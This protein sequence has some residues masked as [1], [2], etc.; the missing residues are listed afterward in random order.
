VGGQLEIELGHRLSRLD[1]DVRLTVDR[2]T[3]ALVGPSGSGKSTILR[4]I[5]GLLGPDRGRIVHD[6]R[7][8]LDTSRGVNLS[9]DAR[10]IGLVYQD[11]ALFPFM[12]VEQN[13]AY[14]VRADRSARARRARSILDRF[15]IGGLAASRPGDLSGGE[16]QRVALARAVASE[17][18]ILL[19]D[20][21]LSALDAVTKAEVA[22]EIDTRLRELRLPTILVSHDFADVVALAGRVAVLQEGRIVQVGPSSELVE[23]PASG[24]VASLAGVNYFAGTARPRDGLTEVSGEGWP[25]PL[26][27]TD[28]ALGPVGVVVYPW[29]ISLGGRAPAGSAL[30][31]IVG[32]VRRIVPIGNRSRVS[33]DGSPPVVAEVTEDSVRHLGLA[34]GVHVVASWKATATRLVVL[35]GNAKAGPDA[36]GSSLQS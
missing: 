19:L 13:V 9:P 31:A 36:G 12:T 34:P 8:L 10:R 35:G 22:A 30:N 17:P 16:R 7:V 5:A 6:G 28:E 14:G 33:V 24:F 21:P 2:E 29:E 15:G 1:V 11:G 18:E 3:L 4:A 20:E 26:L 23:A 32:T 27:S 25:R